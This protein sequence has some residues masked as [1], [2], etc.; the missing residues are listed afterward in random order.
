MKKIV[1]ILICGLCIVNVLGQNN[2]TGSTSAPIKFVT[3]GSDTLKDIPSAEFPPK[4]EISELTL[5]GVDNEGFIS[6]QEKGYLR[7]LIKNVGSGDAYNLRLFASETTGLQG[8]TYDNHKFITKLIKSG[9][10][11]EDSIYIEGRNSLGDGRAKFE[12]TLREANGFESQPAIISILTRKSGKPNIDIT[13]YNLFWKNERELLIQLT[14]QNT[15]STSLKDIKA[16]V[17][18]PKTVFVKGDNVKSLSVLKPDESEDVDFTFVINKEFSESR[19]DVFKVNFLDNNGN[20]FGMQKEIVRSMSNDSRGRSRNE[21]I[22]SVVSDIMI[23]IPVISGELN[24]NTF[25]L[26]IGNEKYSRIQDVPYAENDARAFGEYCNRTFKIPKENITMLINATGNQM[27]EF[28]RELARKAMYNSKGESELLIYFS[29]HGLIA[30]ERNGN[31]YEQY[32][33]PV[34]VS[35]ADASLSI[36][37]RDIYNI[38]NDV[39]FKRASIFLDACNIKGDRAIVKTA[40]YEWKGNVFVFS[41]SS[42]DQTAGAYHE[43]KHGLFTY[44]LLRSIQE[45]KGKIDYSELTEK[46]INNVK[47]HTDNMYDKI[48]TPEI[49]VSPQI[50]DEWRKWRFP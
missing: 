41:S 13:S 36:A 8:L 17:N 45:K 21:E 19:K 24:K 7:F 6:S 39:P 33:V 47:R 35:D 32:L 44:Y 11:R 28:L 22:L 15:G 30:K 5:T 34:D 3:L 29:G 48:Q 50:G 4:L 46:V 37:R 14:V 26:I 10:T 25:A 20:P 42:P 1:T 43:K 23:N 9:E 2:R 49:E 16:K 27:K 40:K 31:E 38:L 18:Y 12:L